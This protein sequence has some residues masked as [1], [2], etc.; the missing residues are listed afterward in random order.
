L[1]FIA[2]NSLSQEESRGNA[3]ACVSRVRTHGGKIWRNARATRRKIESDSRTG[4]M[5]NISDFIT[6][7]FFRGKNGVGRAYLFVPDFSRES[8]RYSIIRR[9]WLVM[10]IRRQ[11]NTD[12]DGTMLWQSG[13]I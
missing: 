4:D 6:S 2:R 8:T 11:R 9:G 3:A 7:V 12:S 13:E 5:R 1:E 10:Q